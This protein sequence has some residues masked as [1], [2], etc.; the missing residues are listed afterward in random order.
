MTEDPEDRIQD[1]LTLAAAWCEH[2]FPGERP[3]L[4]FAVCQK[5][6][7]GVGM[8]MADY[9]SH[10]RRDGPVVDAARWAMSKRGHYIEWKAG[11]DVSFILSASS[12]CLSEHER[13]AA[14]Q[15]FTGVKI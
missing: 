15:F 4:L 11:A 1:D 12:V 5:S 6:S 14:I 8:I 13:I 2:I 7:A 9:S 3:I 10:I